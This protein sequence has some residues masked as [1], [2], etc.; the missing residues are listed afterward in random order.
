[1]DSTVP[2]NEVQDAVDSL[3]TIAKTR[4]FGVIDP[5]RRAAIRHGYMLALEN[6]HHRIV[7]LG[8]QCDSLEVMERADP[9]LRAARSTYVK[10]IYREDSNLREGF[11]SIGTQI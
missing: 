4:I 9:Y 2:V 6:G 7:S 10:K 11:P 8:G 5:K 1:M 3:R